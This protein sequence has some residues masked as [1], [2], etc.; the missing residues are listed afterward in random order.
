M[1]FGCGLAG[2]NDL[3]PG[4]TVDMSLDLHVFL[5]WLTDVNDLGASARVDMSRYVHRVHLLTQCTAVHR[6]A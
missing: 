6:L 3:V 2:V 5:R 4:T 1:F